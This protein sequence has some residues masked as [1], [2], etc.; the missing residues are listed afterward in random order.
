[1]QHRKVPLSVCVH[2]LRPRNSTLLAA[3]AAA[4][5]QEEVAAAE[6]VAQEEGAAAAEAGVEEVKRAEEVV[7]HCHL[8]RHR[9]LKHKHSALPPLK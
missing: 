2:N 6:A 7:R 3:V 5:A 4:V 9:R 8:R 1:M